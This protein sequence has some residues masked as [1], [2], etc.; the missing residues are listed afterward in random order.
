MGFGVWSLK[1]VLEFSLVCLELTS[2]TEL[3]ELATPLDYIGKPCCVSFQLSAAVL[4][5][6]R[7]STLL[8]SA[9]ILAE[10]Q[11]VHPSTY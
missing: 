3:G 7:A 9:A 4:V 11:S 5:G 2:E 1:F 8:A 10:K 6:N